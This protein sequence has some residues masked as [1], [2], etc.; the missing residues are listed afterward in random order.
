MITWQIVLTKFRVLDRG[1][2]VHNRRVARWEIKTEI[3]VPREKV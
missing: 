2:V 1:K 3:R